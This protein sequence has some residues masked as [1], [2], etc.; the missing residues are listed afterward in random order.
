M[1]TSIS[2]FEIIQ[3]TISS[4]FVRIPVDIKNVLVDLEI[5]E[6]IERPFLTGKILIIDTNELFT[7]D[8][9]LNFRGGET[10]D[11]VI[12]VN[13]SSSP[14]TDKSY[15]I[16]HKFT[17]T[18]IERMGK[19][20]D[21][22]TSIVL[23][24]VDPWVYENYLKKFSR[25]FSGTPSE[26]I[27]KILTDENLL[28][29]HPTVLSRYDEPIQKNM[30]VVIPYLTPLG[31]IDF[32]RDRCTSKHGSPFFLTTNIHSWLDEERTRIN[33]YSLDYLLKQEAFNKDAP[34]V[35]S[36]AMINSDP[37]WVTPDQM[38]MDNVEFGAN[39]NSLETIKSGALASD[40]AVTDISTNKRVK[41]SHSIKRMFDAYKNEEVFKDGNEQ[42]IYNDL[43]YY[44]SKPQENLPSMFFHQ[45]VNSSSYTDVSGYYDD[46]TGPDYRK[47]IENISIRNALMQNFVK[48]EVPAYMFMAAESGVGETVSLLFA[49]SAGAADRPDA[50]NLID[51]ERS[52]T[53]LIYSLRHSFSAGSISSS[54]R[55]CKLS[56]NYNL[57]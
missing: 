42:N 46:L 31:A 36:R 40:F 15:N 17:I 57:Q 44:N 25:S 51:F 26:I 6:N 10:L 41:T 48:L 32:V 53:Y 4:P 43:L 22:A 29:L 49:G 8:T 50:N 13:L 19:S 20:N 24:L 39:H 16:K 5:F 55:A 45:I 34:F 12:N 54:M 47:R 14:L 23:S 35:E 18:G 2:Q 3:A 7:S 11:L 28:G 27:N 33:F 56:K 37:S 1:P 9:G 30:K 38:V 52:G 21:A